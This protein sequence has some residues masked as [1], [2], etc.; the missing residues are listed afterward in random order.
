MSHIKIK[1]NKLLIAKAYTQDVWKQ[2]CHVQAQISKVLLY[3]N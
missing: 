3:E 2:D 1:E